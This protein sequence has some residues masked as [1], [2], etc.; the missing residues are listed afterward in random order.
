MTGPQVRHLP[1]SLII[2][3]HGC[4]KFDKFSEV[5]VM[6]VSFHWDGN[7]ADIALVADK[8]TNLPLLGDRPDRFV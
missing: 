6:G 1:L 7:S 8:M 5:W 4:R 3:F 2:Y